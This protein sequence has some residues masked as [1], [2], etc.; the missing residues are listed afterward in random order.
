M[1]RL[2]VVMK[3]S[4]KWRSYVDYIYLN[5]ACHKDSYLLYIIDKLMD[6]SFEYKFLHFMDVYSRYNKFTCES[7]SIL[8]PL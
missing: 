6:N 7:T 4:V 1:S 8:Q 2:V 5:K 3:A